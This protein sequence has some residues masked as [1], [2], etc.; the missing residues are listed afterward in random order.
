MDNIRHGWM[1]YLG[2]EW[3]TFI[4]MN[5]QKQRTYGWKVHLS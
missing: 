2:S 3:I 4:G 1:H 5:G